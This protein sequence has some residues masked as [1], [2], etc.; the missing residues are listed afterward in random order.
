[1]KTNK[2]T[3][4]KLLVFSGILLMASFF[5]VY[6]ILPYKAIWLWFPILV[7]VDYWLNW[8]AKK[9]GMILSDELTQQIIGKSAWATFQ[10]T[11]A[12]IFVTIVYYDMH[13]THI[14]PRYI[15]AYLAG[16]MGIT[17]LAVNTYYN[18]KQGLWD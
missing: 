17:F 1:M 2:L 7:F 3:K 12:V 15:L 16:F 8:Y 11:I 13:R 14:D 5:Y 18:I 9:R 10:L 4:I 6:H